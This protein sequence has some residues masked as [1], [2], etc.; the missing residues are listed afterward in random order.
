MRISRCDDEKKSSI[1]CSQQIFN[2]NASHMTQFAEIN[3]IHQ[4]TNA[5]TII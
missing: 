3:A 4:I 2:K 1:F 5:F